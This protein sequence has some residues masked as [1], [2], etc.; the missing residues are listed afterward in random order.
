MMGSPLMM[1]PRSRANWDIENFYLYYSDCV[2]G[3]PEL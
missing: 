2:I 3:G 1:I